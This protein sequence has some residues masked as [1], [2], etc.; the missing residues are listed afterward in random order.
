MTT[1]HIKRSMRKFFES[2]DGELV[3]ALYEDVDGDIH[4][5]YCTYD[6]DK[7]RLCSCRFYKSFKPI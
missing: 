2:A 3:F 7:H 6:T 5:R 1:I 4:Y